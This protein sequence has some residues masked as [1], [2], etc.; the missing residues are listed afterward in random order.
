M[1]KGV[2]FSV[3]NFSRSWL[4]HGCDL[5]VYVFFGPKNLDF[6][7][8]IIFFIWDPVFCQMGVRNPRRW[9]RFGTFGSI[10]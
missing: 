3:D 9:F 7:P 8:K 4:E 1:G 2:L 10:V 6:G 5:K